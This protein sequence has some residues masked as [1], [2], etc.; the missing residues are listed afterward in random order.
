MEL[1]LETIRR[2]MR[3]ATSK[4][5]TTKAAFYMAEKAE[6]FI[7]EITQRADVLLEARNKER[8]ATNIVQKSKITDELISDVLKGDL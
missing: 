8:E 7:I 6:E 1:G 4:Q 5:I 2:I 3:Q